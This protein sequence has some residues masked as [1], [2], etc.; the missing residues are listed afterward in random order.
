MGFVGTAG[1]KTRETDYRCAGGAQDQN[2]SPFSPLTHDKLA[3]RNH[4]RSYPRAVLHSLA[5]SRDSALRK[6]R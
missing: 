5:L 2:I 6:N 1:R 4:D 3:D